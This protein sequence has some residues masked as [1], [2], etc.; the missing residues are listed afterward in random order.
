MGSNANALKRRRSGAGTCALLPGR[1][2]DAIS[3]HRS[4]SGPS[5]TR[6]YSASEALVH[7]LSQK[8][9]GMLF[10]GRANRRSQIVQEIASASST[11]SMDC[12][13]TANGMPSLTSPQLRQRHNSDRHRTYVSAR[14]VGSS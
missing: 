12:A 11:V 8:K 5:P 9:A 4:D 3:P 6:N 7:G 1:S 14:L 2:L 10:T 13:G